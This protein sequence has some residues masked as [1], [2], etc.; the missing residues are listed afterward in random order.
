MADVSTEKGQSLPLCSRTPFPSAKGASSA[1]IA[2]H[3]LVSGFCLAK[4]WIIVLF[5]G[6]I[7]CYK[8]WPGYRRFFSEDPQ[9]VDKIESLS[10][11]SQMLGKAS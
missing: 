9:G 6:S 4:S 5:E 10:L 2:S 1:D 11:K 3:A 7:Y 8:F